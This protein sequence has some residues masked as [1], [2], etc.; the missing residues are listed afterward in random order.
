M[1]K[2]KKLTKVITG[3]VVTVTELVTGKAVV[4]DFSKAPKDIQEK[5]GPFGAGHK[6]GDAA[7]GCSGQEAV[8]SMQKVV[9]GLMAGNWAV[10]GAKG[11]SVSVSAL[12]SGIDKLPAKEQEAA[13]ALLLK[14]G[15][16]KPAA[17]AGVAPVKK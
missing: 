8:D 5:L 10:R 2:A 16:L 4:F 11:E 1:P 6:I 13:R 7:A 14:L 12:N 15:I 9:D 3:N 17:P